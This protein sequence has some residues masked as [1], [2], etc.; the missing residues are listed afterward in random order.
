[1]YTFISQIFVGCPI[2]ARNISRPEKNI[3]EL[4]GKG[5]RET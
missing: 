5:G 4:I 3:M 1:M 2:N